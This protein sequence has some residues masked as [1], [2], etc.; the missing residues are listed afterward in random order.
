MSLNHGFHLR[1]TKE[2]FTNTIKNLTRQ[3]E[4]GIGLPEGL[5]IGV[6][7]SDIDNFVASLSE[8]G[9]AKNLYVFNISYLKKKIVSFYCTAKCKDDM[10]YYDLRM[11]Y[12]EDWF[13]GNNLKE[14]KKKK[15]K[16]G[17]RVIIN[18]TNLLQ[19][20]EVRW[21]DDYSGVI[22]FLNNVLLKSFSSHDVCKL[23]KI[24]ENS[25]F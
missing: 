20:V 16:G 24:H 25:D 18:S 11:R 23:P 6:V 21:F 1:R 22:N 2:I 7:K 15:E 13:C 3:I 12:L 4:K 8:N 5:K 9:V 19:E 14:F 10:I 17:F